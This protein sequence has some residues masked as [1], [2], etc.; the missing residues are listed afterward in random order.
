MRKR[1]ERFI[2]AFISDEP[3][4]KAEI[5]SAA[6]EQAGLSVRRSDDFLATA[7]AQGLVHRWAFSRRRPLMFATQPQPEEES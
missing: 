5:R 7:E 2:E 6:K 4:T 3:R 1:V